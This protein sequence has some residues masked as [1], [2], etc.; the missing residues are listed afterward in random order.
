MNQRKV[1]NVAGKNARR[2]DGIEKVTGKALYTGDLQL[3]GMA[4]AKILRS[5]LAH[6]RLMK[7]DAS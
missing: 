7:V 3:P 4:Y 1:Y 5:P 2:V 6:A